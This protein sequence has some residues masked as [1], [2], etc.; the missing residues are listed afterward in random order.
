MEIA[1]ALDMTYEELQERLVN[2]SA[3]NQSSDVVLLNNHN[4]ALYQLAKDLIASMIF[5]KKKL[6]DPSKMSG[7]SPRAKVQLLPSPP[8]QLAQPPSHLSSLL[9]EG[10][11][12][13]ETA[14][15]T[16]FQSVRELLKNVT[17]IAS[18]TTLLEE[19]T[20]DPQLVTVTGWVQN[21]RRFQQ[22]ISMFYLADDSYVIDSE[23]K[24]ESVS[25]INTKD[26]FVLVNENE[27]NCTSNEKTTRDKTQVSLLRCILHPQL[28]TSNL[29]AI[30]GNLLCQGA[31]VVLQGRVTSSSEKDTTVTC[32]WI[33][34]Q[35][36]LIKCSP[37]PGVV[38]LLLDLL[39][40]RCGRDSD[41]PSLNEIAKEAVRALRMT[42]HEVQKIV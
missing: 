17:A 12:Q 32:L 25:I 14:N 42:T 40:E 28:L 33:T 20:L 8:R 23:S 13:E 2:F 34:S 37:R 7:S 35:P 30:Y 4:E 16:S 1:T 26:D 3:V 41:E 11:Y 5:Q 36:K 38:R 24:V 6:L 21:R 15:I 39:A 19:S 27:T 10:R 18:A 22:N 31:K 9:K 29:V